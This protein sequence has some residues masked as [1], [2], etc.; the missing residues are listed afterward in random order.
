MTGKSEVVVPVSDEDWPIEALELRDGFA[1]RLNVYRA[2]AHH[3]ELLL[4]WKDFRNHLIERSRLTQAQSEI[5]ILRTGHRHGSRYEW[6]HHVLRG[7]D[8]GLDPSRIENVMHPE[9]ASAEDAILIEAVDSLVDQSK[10]SPSLRDKLV[11]LLGLDGTMD[12]VATVGMYTTLAFIIE[13]FAV[14][15]EPDIERRFMDLAAT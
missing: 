6:V 12:L 8:A 2:M 1:G 5:V 10:L 9:G 15:L 7:L 11:H 3:P 14:P 4:A 13:T